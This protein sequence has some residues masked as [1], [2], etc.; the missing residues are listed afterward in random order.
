MGGTPSRYEETNWDQDS[1]GIKKDTDTVDGKPPSTEQTKIVMTPVTN[2]IGLPKNGEWI[3]TDKTIDGKVLYKTVPAGGL[4]SGFRFDVV[5]SEDQLLVRVLT[6]QFGDVFNIFWVDKPTFSGQEKDKGASEHYDAELYKRASFKIAQDSNDATVDFVTG[7]DTTKTVLVIENVLGPFERFQTSDAS[8]GKKGGLTGFW[9]WD[10]TN[11][12]PLIGKSF[13]DI[14][15]VKESDVVLHI[16]AAV[17]S[18]A[19]IAA[20]RR[21]GRVGG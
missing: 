6:N 12:V 15:M 2:M 7:K 17:A 9:K 20:Q 13:V 10:K 1:G 4:S 8:K 16:I 14:E 5:D 11:P 18:H 21:G 3:I 19:Y